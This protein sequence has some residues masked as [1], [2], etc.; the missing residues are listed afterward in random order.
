MKIT[1]A[2][3]GQWATP[4]SRYLRPCR[5]LGGIDRGPSLEESF[6]PDSL[7]TSCRAC[8]CDDAGLDHEE[9]LSPGC[10]SWAVWGGG[11]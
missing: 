2:T 4:P 9:A 7:P 1:A 3:S 5:R 8:F 10:L 11:N 6:F